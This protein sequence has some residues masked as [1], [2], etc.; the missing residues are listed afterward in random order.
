MIQR[1]P[2]S[3]VIESSGHFSKFEV[4]C[5]EILCDELILNSWSCCT[6]KA[7]TLVKLW[8]YWGN[9]GFIYF[10]THRI[11]Q[12]GLEVQKSWAL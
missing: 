9:P 12:N 8:K 2:V 10:I 7:N 4:T 11:A 6:K 3:F 5:G 1:Q